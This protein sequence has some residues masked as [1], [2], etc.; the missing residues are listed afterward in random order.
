[1]IPYF[2]GNRENIHKFLTC[3]D[4][5]W[6]VATTR[7]QQVMSMHIAK[8]KLSGS[9]YNV[10]KYKVMNDRPEFKLVL[11]NQ[12]FER[13]TIARIQTELLSSRQYPNEDVRTFANRIEKLTIDLNDACIASEG[14]NARVTIENLNKKSSLKAFVEGLRDP[15][16]LII[17]AS[18]FDDFTNAVEAACEEERNFK[19][20]N[21][22]QTKSDFK[23]KDFKKINCFKCGKN[24]HTS[25]QCYA[26]SRSFPSYPRQNFTQIPTK[27]EANVNNIRVE[28]R[29][30]RKFGHSI[31][32]CR[33]RSYNNSR[34]NSNAFHYQNPQRNFINQNEN[35]GASSNYFQRND[36]GPSTSNGSVTRAC[37]IKSA[38]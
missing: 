23:N 36:Q 8:S 18:R 13:R 34:K 2:D 21:N 37:E 16:Q 35:Q 28:C 31:A 33:K 38:K 27:T 17:K 9:A 15:F 20:R 12:Y 22:F 1:M 14:Q 4:V 6:E 7:A 5:V 32:E 30:C 19:N 10:I 3:C 26:N 29:Y 24:N 25:D 11:Q